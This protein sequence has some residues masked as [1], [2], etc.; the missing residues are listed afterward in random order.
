MENR[1]YLRALEPED[2]DRIHKWHNDQK[3]Y[4]IMGGHFHYVSKAATEEWLRKRMEY[5]TDEVSLAICIKETSQHIGNIYLKKIDWIDRQANLDIFIGEPEMRSG[6]YGTEA[7]QL[8]VDHAV[9]D[10][11]LRRIYGIIQKG[12]DAIKKVT[13]KVGLTV[14]GTLPKC[15]FFDGSWK[16]YYLVAVRFDENGNVIK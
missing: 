15:T 2:L 16:D 12:N 7:F 6:G 8:L 9:K 5:R 14:E 4:R 10:L 13:E 11:G 3:L 1:I